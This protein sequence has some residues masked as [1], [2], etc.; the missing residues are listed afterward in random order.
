MKDKCPKD[1]PKTN[2]K[3][4]QKYGS[5]W[6][7]EFDGKIEEISIN[8]NRLME[9]HD[10]AR[11]CKLLCKICTVTMI[12][13]LVGVIAVCYGNWLWWLEDRDQYTKLG[14]GVS[15]VVNQAKIATYKAEEAVE[16]A[17]AN[18][19]ESKRNLIAQTKAILS[20]Q[21]D[22]RSMML[23]KIHEKLGVYR[24]TR[25]QPTVAQKARFLELVKRQADVK[26]DQQ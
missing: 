10:L 25:Q 2:L 4:N 14:E 22:N 15:D 11:Q 7:S 6:E 16:T 9:I 23:G 12:A 19:V 17:V 20:G 26:A 21:K 8:G 3:I 1:S 13:C 24:V 18:T 5:E